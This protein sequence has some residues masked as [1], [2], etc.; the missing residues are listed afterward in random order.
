[1]AIDNKE[2]RYI[3]TLD[4]GEKKYEFFSDFKGERDM[5]YEVLKNSRKTAKDIKNSITKKP[6]SLSKIIK[7]VE[8]EGVGKLREFAENEKQKIAGNY[9]EM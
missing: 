8:K 1:V 4:V 3:I 5:W 7:I 6:R 9:W 2:D